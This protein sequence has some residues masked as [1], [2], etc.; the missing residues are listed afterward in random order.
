MREGAATSVA[1]TC[2]RRGRTPAE[3]KSPRGLRPGCAAAALGAARL[4]P[5]PLNGNSDCRRARLHTR[6]LAGSSGRVYSGKYRDGWQR[7]CQQLTVRTTVSLLCSLFPSA[8]PNCKGISPV[9][10][11]CG[12]M[13]GAGAC[14]MFVLEIKASRRITIRTFKTRA[15]KNFQL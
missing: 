11:K 15:L 7:E 2:A 9:Q 5:F 12:D 8:R 3:G 13:C 4:R 10:P 6:P 14:A 1:S